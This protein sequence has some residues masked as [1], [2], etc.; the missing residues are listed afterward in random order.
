LT[1]AL[2][3]GCA[4]FIGSHLTESLL[5]DG[6]AVLGVDCFND[7]YRRADKRAN[8]RRAGEHRDFRLVEA[9]LVETDARALIEEC[10]VVYHLAGEPGVRGSW[11]QRFDRYT[12]HNV[13]ATQRLLEAARAVPGRRVVYASS[14]SVYGDAMD[15]PTRE[16]ATPQ[17]LSPYG[18]T[19]LAAEHMCVLYEE[20]HGVDTIAL[21]YFSVYGP[22]QRPDMAFRRFCEAVLAGRPIE[23]Y[24]NGSQTRDF[25]YVA[26]IVAATRAAGEGRATGVF[27]VGGGSR[28]SL[29]RALEVLAGVAGRPLDVRRGERESGDVQD[30]G[31][32]ISRA[33]AQLG[34]APSTSVEEGLAAEFEWVREWGLRQPARARAAACPA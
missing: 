28:I 11:G 34:F 24:G 33:R 32:D 9:D 27:N 16:D 15:L 18:V 21:R 23:L 6:H 22:R 8:L 2:V 20:E 14:S 10:D 17:P 19:K 29:N 30:T 3:T 5:E 1:K 4:G 31:A 25:T 13:A 12:H 7:N 26:D